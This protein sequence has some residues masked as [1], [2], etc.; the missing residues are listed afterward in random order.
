MSWLEVESKVKVKNPDE[1]RKKIKTLARFL[2][3][4]EKSDNYFELEKGYPEKAFRIRDTSGKYVV[5]FKKRLKEF[6]DDEIVVKEEFEFSL[7]KSDLDSFTKLC[8]D[9][10]FKTW[11]KKIKHCEIYEYKK[12][13][14]LHLELNKV[15]KLGYFL[16][17]EYLCQKKDLEKAKS[18]I[19][20]V[21]EELEIQKNDIDNTGYTKMLWDLKK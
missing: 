14:K 16:E 8:E 12:D 3:K 18:Q 4:E 7:N 1:L 15:E 21:I 5:N 20:K 10:G 6:Y 19:R 17:L 11:I 13:K 9:L 2:K